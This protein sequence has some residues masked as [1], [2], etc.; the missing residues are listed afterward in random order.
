[1]SSS[2]IEFILLAAIA[3]FIGWR[4]YITLG[5]DNG[6]PDGRSRDP[7]P[8]NAPT[9]GGTQIKPE[10]P[11]ELRPAFTGPAAAGMEAIFA[12]DKTFDPKT[13]MTGARGAYEMLVTAFAAGD[14]T[15]LK[16]YLDTDVYEAWDL[17]IAE[18]EVS[19][20]E[21]MQLLRLRH[22]EINDASL[23][24]EGMARVTVEFE[25]ELG[26]GENTV[27]SREYWTF[28]RQTKSSDP[29]WL[30]DDVDTAD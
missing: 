23:D 19:G 1:M 17:A 22:A 3:L 27:K 11:T 30:L 2:M 21:G 4:L 7:R 12:V 8:V 5:Q 9:P 24:D 14:R 10:A 26:D 13:F 15:A 16:P 29:N 6:P 20:A 28:M 25:A 18:R